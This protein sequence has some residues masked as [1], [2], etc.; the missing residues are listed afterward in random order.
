MRGATEESSAARRI[1]AGVAIL[2]VLSGLLLMRWSLESGFIPADVVFGLGQIALGIGLVLYWRWARWFAL[3]A[4]FLAV[5]SAFVFP[6]ALFLLRPADGFDENGRTNLLFTILA[7]AFGGIGYAGLGFLRSEV[8]RREYAKDQRAEQALGAERSSAVVMSAAVW[9]LL[10]ALATA[11]GLSPLRW[12]LAQALGAQLHPTDSMP[13]LTNPADVELPPSTDAAPAASVRAPSASKLPDLLL[14][15][16]CIH[17]ESLVMA[18]FENRGAGAPGEEFQISYGGVQM[19][20]ATD[21]SIGVVP[22]PGERARAA[23]GNAVN[24]TERDGA[25]RDVNLRIDSANQIVESNENNNSSRFPILFD[26]IYPVNLPACDPPA[27][28]QR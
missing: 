6:V 7:F 1:K 2:F 24:W 27:N 10:L 9:L 3:G 15:G 19:R 14:T 12:L 11:L 21:T 13:A 26:T 17:G 22:A 4:C 28:P 8:A 16:L 18:V 23:L 5:V 25:R 20:P